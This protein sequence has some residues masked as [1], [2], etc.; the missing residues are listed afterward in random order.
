MRIRPWRR[1]PWAGRE[2]ED[3]AIGGEARAAREGESERAVVVAG[4]ER[5][6]GKK[7]W[8]GKKNEIEGG[9]STSTSEGQESGEQHA[10]VAEGRSLCP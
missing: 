10:V 1:S 7:R 5:D 3:D 4:G 2:A 6:G 9:D 8:R